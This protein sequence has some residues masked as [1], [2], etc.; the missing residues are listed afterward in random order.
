MLDFR[1]RIGS[2]VDCACFEVNDWL[3]GRLCL[4]LDQGLAQR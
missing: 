4:I 2:E 3:R 1:S